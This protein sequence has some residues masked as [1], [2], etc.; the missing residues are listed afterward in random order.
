MFY[1][2]ASE[3]VPRLQMLHDSGVPEQFSMD[4]LLFKLA[5]YE[6]TPIETLEYVL[7]QLDLVVE[8]EIRE[9]QELEEAGLHA[10]ERMCLYDDDVMTSSKRRHKYVNPEPEDNVCDVSKRICYLSMVS[11]FLFRSLCSE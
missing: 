2:L 1:Q 5:R 8:R 3:T 4:R 7:P 9:R 10:T 11:L 6:K